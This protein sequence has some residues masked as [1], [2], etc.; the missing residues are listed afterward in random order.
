M[1][2]C[3]VKYGKITS[4]M[5]HVYL[6]SYYTVLLA[7]ASAFPSSQWNVILKVYTKVS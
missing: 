3:Y 6:Y 7:L 1:V 4:I 2:L 5:P